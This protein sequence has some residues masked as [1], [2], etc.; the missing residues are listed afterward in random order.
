[1][2]IKIIILLSLITFFGCKERNS[3]PK[4]NTI[5]NVYAYENKFCPDYWKTNLVAFENV[6]ECTINL[7]IFDN[8]HK[9]IDKIMQEKDSTKVDVVLGIDNMLAAKVIADSI[10]TPLRLK[11]TASSNNI[12][13]AKE[14][15]LIPLFYSP[16]AFLYE[17]EEFPNVPE[18]FGEMQDGIWKN[19]LIVSN[20]LT[21]AEG[22]SFLGWSIA[23][24]GTNGYGH[25]WRSM[26]ANIY[27]I[28]T[29][30][31]KAI[32][33]FLADEA[34]LVICPASYLE[35]FL[36]V[37]NTDKYNTFIPAEGTFIY[38]EFGGVLESSENKKEATNL[39][40]YLLSDE[41]QQTI[42]SQRWMIPINKNINHNLPIAEYEIDLTKNLKDEAIAENLTKWG[43]RWLKLTQ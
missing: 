12:I 22:N 39:L 6:F 31:D 25:F 32:D 17:V 23:A 10:F 4:Q 2:R 16:L 29:S 33:M 38:S 40:N 27:A 36:Q 20:P 9:M 14:D 37:E 15:K 1:M 30:W 5:I 13:K 19:K 41:F 8:T 34:P 3:E 28:T 42:V 43:K 24:F 7:T 26:K 11:N 18:T 21:S 35:Y